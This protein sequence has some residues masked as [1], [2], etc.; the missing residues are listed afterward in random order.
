VNE[1]RSNNGA[2]NETKVDLI[3]RSM[4]YFRL[5]LYPMGALDE[6]VDFLQ[7]LAELFNEAH[8]ASL[9]HSYA[10]LLYD[11]LTP[12]GAVH[13]THA[14]PLFKIYLLSRLQLPR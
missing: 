6:S 5:S 11:L 14:L 9:K 4:R 10:Q 7:T 2:V 13:Y 12:I 3:I 8:S 1:I